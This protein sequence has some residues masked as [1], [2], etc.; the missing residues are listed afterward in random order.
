MLFWKLRST[1][2]CHLC[3]VL[4]LFLWQSLTNIAV[5]F[6]GS[7]VAKNLPAKQETQ[8]RSL[9]WEDTPEKEMAIHCNILA[10]GN[11]MNRGAWWP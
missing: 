10:G 7:S 11:P 6:P 3:I 4:F 2:I 1:I 8:V 9:G 5:G